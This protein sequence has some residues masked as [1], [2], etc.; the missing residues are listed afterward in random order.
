MKPR[1]YAMEPDNREPISRCP[2]FGNPING[3][4]GER[5][6][7]II[8]LNGLPIVVYIPPI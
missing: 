8:G 4:M 1:P 3:D 7:G 6:G 5:A 2:V